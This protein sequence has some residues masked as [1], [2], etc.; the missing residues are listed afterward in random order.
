[1]RYVQC[2]GDEDS[3]MDCS[4]YSAGT[5]TSCHHEDDAT[6]KCV[7]GNSL[8]LTVWLSGRVTHS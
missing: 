5:Y 8:G 1:M 6:V 3:L 4:S 2:N 7:P